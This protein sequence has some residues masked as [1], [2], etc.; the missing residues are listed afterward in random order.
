MRAGVS[1]GGIRAE[2]EA[3]SSAKGELKKRQASHSTGRAK[4]KG[5]SPATER[6]RGS[7]GRRRQ[8]NIAR[9]PNRVGRNTTIQRRKLDSV[10]ARSKDTRAPCNRQPGGERNA[11]R[12]NSSRDPAKEEANNPRV[13]PPQLI[14]LPV[15]R[16][17]PYPMKRRCCDMRRG[18]ETA[19][20]THS[21]VGDSQRR[22]ER[23]RMACPRNF[24]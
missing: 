11:R 16:R 17:A 20:P 10:V 18:M 1:D 5:T 14:L 6:N 23:L 8:R 21:A 12:K 24:S 7:A 9:H 22:G 13:I 3:R 15:V 2:C 4:H 19:T